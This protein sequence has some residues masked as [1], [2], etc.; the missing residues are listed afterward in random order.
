MTSEQISSQSVYKLQLDIQALKRNGRLTLGSSTPRHVME[1][2]PEEPEPEGLYPAWDIESVAVS[3][4]DSSN[5]DHIFAETC[6]MS[7]PAAS[8]SWKAG[9]AECATGGRWNKKAIAVCE[10]EHR[11]PCYTFSRSSTILDSFRST[12]VF[13][14]APSLV[15]AG[16]SLG[17]SRR[18]RNICLA[19][20][21]PEGQ[22]SE[23]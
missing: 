13:S 17:L 4:G 5:A 11:R 15:S 23:L 7:C 3:S 14:A 16:S 9:A 12:R 20:R 22:L 10:H 19:T 2:S 21:F 18:P 8:S 6:T 1:G